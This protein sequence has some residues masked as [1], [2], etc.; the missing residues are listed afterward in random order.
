MKIF[1]KFREIPIYRHATFVLAFKFL[2]TIPSLDIQAEENFSASVFI[3]ALVPLLQP[4]VAE[5][6]DEKT[7]VDN[8]NA[9]LS[10]YTKHLTFV[11]I[12]GDSK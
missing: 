9:K 10:Q 4:Y 3:D 7:D 5:Y 6:C 12:C 8:N 1:E 2:S 11:Y